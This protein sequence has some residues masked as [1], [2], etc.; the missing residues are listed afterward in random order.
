MNN[1]LKDFWKNEHKKIR[2]EKIIKKETKIIKNKTEKIK[3]DFEGLNLKTKEI[4]TNE[5][6]PKFLLIQIALNIT[7]FILSIYI[8]TMFLFIIYINFALFWL[9][10]LISIIKN[11]FKK[12]EMKTIWIVLIILVPI[13]V[14]LYQ[15]FKQTQTI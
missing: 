4:R 8:T 6:K 2:A 9:Y 13:S 1:E 15:D 7:L 5:Y 11:D 12:S 3:N 10:A 14:Y